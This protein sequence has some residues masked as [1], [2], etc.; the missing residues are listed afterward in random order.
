MLFPPNLRRC[1]DFGMRGPLWCA[2]D[3]ENLPTA[4]VREQSSLMP[5]PSCRNAR[6]NGL[7]RSAGAVTGVAVTP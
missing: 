6:S 3:G 7:S 4:L 1:L 2:A 5:A